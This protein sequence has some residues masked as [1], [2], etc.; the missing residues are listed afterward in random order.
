[1]TKFLFKVILINPL[2]LLVMYKYHDLILKPLTYGVCTTLINTSK[3]FS[4]MEV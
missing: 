4:I 3:A 2:L 1:M